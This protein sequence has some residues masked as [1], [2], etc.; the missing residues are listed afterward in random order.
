MNRSFDVYDRVGVEPDIGPYSDLNRWGKW[1]TWF[2]RKS[3]ACFERFNVDGDG[4]VSAAHW[5]KCNRRY[6]KKPLDINL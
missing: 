3:R 1:N 4:F 2:R 5:W 6:W